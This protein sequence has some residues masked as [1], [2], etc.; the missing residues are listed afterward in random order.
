MKAVTIRTPTEDIYK[1]FDTLKNCKVQFIISHNP[2]SKQ[3]FVGDK[4]IAD[5]EK[6]RDGEL[7]CS[8]ITNNES[9]IG[10]ALVS[11]SQQ[12]YA[13]EEM[14]EGKNLISRTKDDM[15]MWKFFSEPIPTTTNFMFCRSAPEEK[16]MIIIFGYSGYHKLLVTHERGMYCVKYNVLN[17]FSE[18]LLGLYQL[19][20]TSKTFCGVEMKVFDLYR[21]LTITLCLQEMHLPMD[22]IKLFDKFIC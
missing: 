22:A 3:L 21:I 19:V 16:N 20:R 1:I 12:N 10:E 5:F 7:I 9:A 18:T 11:Q 8:I 4:E 6:I 13:I 14:H 17:I 2:R 15:C